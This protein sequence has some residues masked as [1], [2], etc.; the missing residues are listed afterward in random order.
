MHILRAGSVVKG[1]DCSSQEHKFN[2]QHTY[3]G[4]QPSLTLGPRNP[5]PFSGLQ[6]HSTHMVHGHICWQNI[7]NK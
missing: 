1:T 5:I 2:F 7:H 6:G 4:S 3:G